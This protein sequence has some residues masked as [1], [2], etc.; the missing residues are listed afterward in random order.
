MELDRSSTDIV[1]S[2]CKNGYAFNRDRSDCYQDYCQP[3][4]AVV[5]PHCRKQNQTHCA[6]CEQSYDLVDGICYP[7]VRNCKKF[8]T[9][10]LCEECDDYYYLD[11]S[12]TSC[13][14]INFTKN[15]IAGNNTYC[16]KC[17][18][19]F[20]YTLDHKACKEI[21]DDH[22]DE[23]Y[24]NETSFVCTKCIDQYYYQEFIK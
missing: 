5:Q 14:L 23:G 15:C 4:F 9:S 3:I 2:L 13:Y 20:A 8:A 10:S 22:C 1:C 6:T 7:I 16:S 11:Q 12:M 18:T 21:P 19:R 17:K 24:W